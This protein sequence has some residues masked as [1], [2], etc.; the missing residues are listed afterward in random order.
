MINLTKKLLA[1]LIS[2][3]LIFQGMCLVGNAS[4]DDMVAYVM[5]GSSNTASY[6]NVS[7]VSSDGTEK[8]NSYD[9]LAEGKYVQFDVNVAETATYIFDVL[10]CNELADSIATLEVTGG[11]TYTF[12]LTKATMSGLTD[13]MI[14]SVNVELTQG[15]NTIKIIGG[16]TK[17]TTQGTRLRSVTVKKIPYVYEPDYSYPLNKDT[18]DDDSVTPSEK[19]SY[20]E[21]VSSS[22]IYYTVS[23]VEPGYY[24]LS[25]NY[26]RDKDGDTGIGL[27][28]N[29]VDY[30]A[31][32]APSTG[33]YGKNGTDLLF[34]TTVKL[35]SGDNRI[36]FTGST[37]GA[38]SLTGF[39]L[40]KTEFEP[41][42]I[43]VPEVAMQNGNG[44]DIP[45]I[46]NGSVIAEV[47]V[48]QDSDPVKLVF[49]IY[50]D[51]DDAH[52]LYKAFALDA[53][54][55][56]ESRTFSLLINN[57]DMS[58][59]ATYTYKV[60]FFGGADNCT[61]QYDPVAGE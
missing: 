38:Y 29:D 16:K 42:N 47:S 30:G 31:F 40:E 3:L 54:T 17:N 43:L 10:G 21:V 37:A 4:G 41:E 27:T 8:K 49:A 26:G 52:S 59:G 7:D 28:V 35:N 5:F 58:D 2:V 44:E 56:D 39:S 53:I 32:N 50:R 24:I 48:P 6:V 60:F 13:T 33:V 25:V 55:E 19:T 22:R 36:K 11:N 15:K 1:I 9:L 34:L 61:P 57:I 20:V 45:G 18:I 14:T 51:K 46:A 23:D 12:G